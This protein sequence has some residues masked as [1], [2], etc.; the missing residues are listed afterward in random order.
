[1][2]GPTVDLI[3]PSLALLFAG[4]F[5]GL[6]RVDTSRK[7][8]MGFA[9]GFFALFLAMSLHIVFPALGNEL[10][11]SVLHGLACLS[12]IAIVWGAAARLGQKIPL[13]AMLFVTVVSGGL[14]FWALDTNKSMAAL[15]IQNGA[16]GILFGTGAIT[17]WIARP[18]SVL[19]RIIIWAMGGIAAFGLIRPAVLILQEVEIALLIQRKTEFNTVSLMII[20]ALTV[21]LATSLIAVAIREAIEIKQGSHRVDPVSGFLDRA[22]FDHACEDALGNAHRL[23]LPATLAVFEIDRFGAFKDEWGQETSNLAIRDLSDILRSCQRDGD[24]VGRMSEHQFGILLVGMGSDSGLKLALDLRDE[25]KR[26]WLEMV[27]GMVNVSLS[28]AVVEAP[29]G[30]TYLSALRLAFGSLGKAK[31]SGSNCIIVDG[32]EVTGQKLGR[33][34]TASIV[35]HG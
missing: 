27:T 13:P 9:A 30:Q 12:V 18:M 25:I 2:Q 19:D 14:L 29:V 6:W 26:K 28:C 34:E 1:M 17:L 11:T 35:A 7:H 15:I 4:A 33:N 16:S 31:T 8:L 3:W 23:A 21:V 32:K 24:I 22:T 20:T 10:L 5:L